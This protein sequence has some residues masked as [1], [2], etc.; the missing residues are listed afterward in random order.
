MLRN[1][2]TRGIFVCV[3][4]FLLSL[5]VQAYPMPALSRRTI[6]ENFIA[7]EQA[8]HKR[9]I[10]FARDKQFVKFN[11]NFEDDDIRAE[12]EEVI[13]QR[14]SIY[15][16]NP[17]EQP[18][19]ANPDYERSQK[20][21][22]RGFYKA[23][24]LIAF[25]YNASHPGYN[26]SN[27]SL[28]GYRFLALEGPQKP[29]HVN[30]FKHLLINYDIK[31]IVRLT[32]DFEEGVFKTENYWANNTFTDENNATFVSL[33][34]HEEEKRKPYIYRYY[35]IDNWADRS[36]VDPEE[37]LLFVQNIRKNYLQGEILAV[38]CS[39]GVGRTGTFIAAFLLLDE[40]DKQIA[41]GVPITELDLSIQEIVYKITIQRAYLVGGKA[42]YLSL[43]RL[44][45]EYLKQISLD[46]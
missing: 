17:G 24:H 41:A 36:G 20:L 15:Y 44:L 6:E 42:Q 16:E 28:N 4:A 10:D 31:T 3:L 5:S 40:V 12:F 30:H 32:E 37:L 45:R 11:P 8:W 1:F 14:N 35:V 18:L 27:V 19:F 26:S 29:E 9:W 39:A 34:L 22:A 21:L 38:H 43:H 33:T 23:P 46:T 2:V 13:K 7:A 25:A